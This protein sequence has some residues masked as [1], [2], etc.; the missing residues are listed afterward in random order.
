M[1][2]KYFTR[3]GNKGYA[4]IVSGYRTRI[5]DEGRRGEEYAV[6]CRDD[7]VV[8]MILDFRREPSTLSFKVN[9][10]EYGPSY[11]NLVKGQYRMAVT[12]CVGDSVT[13]CNPEI[14]WV[15]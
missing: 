12:L 9:D 15:I 10:I 2:K 3:D 1:K 4:Y 13:I 6:K 7:N 11:Q 8:D 14:K 5:I